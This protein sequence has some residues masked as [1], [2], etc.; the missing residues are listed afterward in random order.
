MHT[1]EQYRY[2]T[3]SSMK[4]LRVAFCVRSFVALLQTFHTW[5]TTRNV[6]LPHHHAHYRYVCHFFQWKSFLTHWT[7]FIVCSYA[8]L[9]ECDHGRWHQRDRW[10]LELVCGVAWHHDDVCFWYDG[11]LKSIFFFFIFSIFCS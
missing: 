4:K 1:Y 7:S 10:M 5:V 6:T 9:C 8:L 3:Y 11:S 2:S